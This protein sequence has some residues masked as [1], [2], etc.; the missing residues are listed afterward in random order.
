[1]NVCSCETHH[2]FKPKLIQSA[3]QSYSRATTH[4]AQW[5]YSC[6]R[7]DRIYMH[8]NKGLSSERLQPTARN[9]AFSYNWQ[10]IIWLELSRFP[11]DPSTSY[12]VHNR[13]LVAGLS[14]RTTGFFHSQSVWDL[15][16]TKQHYVRSFSD[17]CF[18]SSLSVSFHQR[19]TIIHPSWTQYNLSNWKQC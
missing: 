15:Q 7:F 9:R 11:A 18:S 13:R 12:R 16:W 3:W 17:Y 14:P 19:S 4:P 8:E 10:Q 1:M 5:P 6:F 2:T